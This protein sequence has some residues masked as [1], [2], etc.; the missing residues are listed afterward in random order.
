MACEIPNRTTS[1]I[2]GEEVKMATLV[3]DKVFIS[4]SHQDREW[5]ERLQTMMK[6]LVRTG[7]A[8]PWTDTMI[9]PGTDWYEQIKLA[10]ATAKVGV[11][12]VSSNFLASDFIAE[13]ELSSLLSAAA[14]EGLQVCWVMVSACLHETSGLSRFQAAHD[15]S[16]PL[17]SLTP[18]ELN[19]TLANIARV[20]NELA[21]TVAPPPPSE[22]KAE[23]R[24]L[25]V[26]F[27]DLMDAAELSERFDIEEVNEVVR[28]Y[29]A[30]CAEVVERYAGHI[31]HCLG[32]RLLVYFGY[33]I[34]HE[35]DALRAVHT[36]VGIIES[37]QR[38]NSRLQQEMGIRLR[39]RL[40]IHTGL[41]V[42]VDMGAGDRRELPILG[43]LNL[44]DRLKELG[45]PDSVT[46]SSTTYRSV[47]RRFHC[48]ALG[49]YS[50][51]GVSRPVVAYQ[52][53]KERED[54]Y[55][56]TPLVGREQELGLL[57]ERW[58][59]VGEGLGQ[60]VM[61]SAE[62]GLG[63]SRL[64]QEVKMHLA[65]EPHTRLEC[66]CSPYH[67]DSPF[68]AIIDLL[69]RVLPLR[70]AHAP[71]E[72]LAKL[73][74][75]L[76]HYYI[77]QPEIIPLLASLL[78]LP[79]SEHYS[80]L[81]LSAQ[82]QR[83]KTLEALLRIVL[84]LARDQP[85]LF[86]VEDLHWVDP[87]T[88]ELVSLLID[89]AAT[90]PILIL[91]TCRPEFHPS[92]N[93]RAH[94]TPITLSRL[95]RA[96]VEVMVERVAGDKALPAEVRQQLVT[97]TDGVPLFVE[98]LTKTVLESG[99][100]RAYKGNYE[101]TE[102][103]PAVSIP[104]TLRDSLEA[105]L[106]RLAGVKE[107]AQLG[108]ILGREFSLEL[109]QAI[110]PWDEPTLQRALSQL[111][112]A[113]VLYQRG[114][115][116]QVSYTFKHALIQEAAYESL[117]RRPRQEYHRQI[118]E[119]LARRFPDIAELQPEL[120]A[121]HYTASDLSGLAVEYWRRAGQ[122][123]IER[124]AYVEAISHLTKGLHLLNNVPDAPERTQQE[125]L[126]LTTLGPALMATKGFGAPQVQEAYDRARE[127]CERMGETPH[128]FPV[129][130]G[131]ATFYIVRAELS[132]ARELSEGLV[133]LAQRAKVQAMLVEAYSMLGTTCFYLGAMGSAREHLE[134]GIAQYN[135]Q[136]HR[137]RA[138]LHVGTD[139]G[140]LCLIYAAQVSWLLGYPDQALIKS[141]EALCLAEE[142][143]HPFSLA[144]ALD[145]AAILH[146]FRREWQSAQERAEAAMT[147]STKE[148]FPLWLAIGMIL[149]GRTLVEQ[150]QGAEGIA[151][152]RQGSAIFQAIG[153]KVGQPY[154]L[155]LIA[156]AHGCEGHPEEGLK[157]LDEA[158]A[159]AQKTGERWC[160]AELYRYRGDLL[161]ARSTE[162]D[163]EAEE[164]FQRALSVTHHQLAK[165]LEL[166]TALSLSRLWQ[167]QGK[168]AKARELL[169]PIYGWFKE[170]F[171]TAEVKETGVVLRELS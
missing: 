113:E 66:R 65:T 82:Q 94:V 143:S 134:E 81:G 64:V 124:S 162:H 160:A 155:A 117:L 33:P 110:S 54:P 42:A 140:V 169:R 135:S 30:T 38:L 80:P 41:A 58:A 75:T 32:D 154:F 1:E 132:T 164:C 36:G 144:Y 165:S 18:A 11:I 146:Q 129:L 55:E 9:R 31:G 145:F 15:I 51:G 141:S 107:V 158:L 35:D 171:D 86:I 150:G 130:R 159:A 74:E 84:M 121:H 89:Q 163:I 152:M 168:Q 128:L 57:L 112:E 161:L 25:T 142:L 118:A 24:Q 114:L 157:I 72:K 105:R 95:S 104:A 87:S 49:T 70:Q 127:L 151:Q 7:T 78:S 69:Q 148:G 108:A 34:R 85:L 67:Q 103:L 5:L 126:L 119:V 22:P 116:P 2:T 125:L 37:I 77:S 19:S 136:Q 56:L 48:Q 45:V 21:N 90:V 166:R 109:L 93:V 40:G 97:K 149:R 12:L 147:L 6:P 99:L 76:S 43:E 102:Q 139:P 91:L 92:W 50:I 63:K 62:P 59:Q 131:L 133:R 123:S 26:L 3:R 101:L 73:E 96:Q 167:R 79:L 120:V 8:L 23:R 137:S 111:V 100:L 156:E 16:R 20:I 88:L 10:L 17:D 28:T 4:Y 14:E 68:Y 27:C 29:Q 52:V 71:K 170:G 115:P 60:V 106:D 138:F 122:R 61:L 39:V 83:Q 53:L 13:V 46:L 98:E 153:A 44:G 47:Q